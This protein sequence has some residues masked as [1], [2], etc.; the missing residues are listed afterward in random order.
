MVY[1]FTSTGLDS[2]KVSKILTSKILWSLDQELQQFSPMFF[3][4]A[5]LAQPQNAIP[6]TDVSD[7]VPGNAQKG[8][9]IKVSVAGKFTA[10][11]KVPNSPIV[12][13][14][15]AWS[16][17]S[18][19]LNKHKYV[20]ISM[21][22]VAKAVQGQ[23]TMD[24]LAR[25]QAKAIAEAFERDIATLATGFSSTVGSGDGYVISFDT[26]A[27]V[28][29]KFFTNGIDI[30]NPENRAV[31]YVNPYAYADILQ[32]RDEYQ[33]AGQKG[34]DQA[35][36][37]DLIETPHGVLISRSNYLTTTGGATKGMVLTK[38]GIMVAFGIKPRVQSDYILAELATLQVA[39]VF[40]GVA[41]MRDVAGILLNSDEV[42]A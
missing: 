35:N 37:G 24:A 14:V 31:A 41:E 3:N 10:K 42:N 25:S 39:D 21:E 33:I 26:F 34:L 5:G 15:N 36:K 1:N 12:P 6:L 7:Q 16:T 20:A 19:T 28:N 23:V 4:N 27:E 8:D 17:I 13:Q 11:D 30:R 2:Q 18:L 38:E 29:R 22:D 32:G 9:T 40:Y